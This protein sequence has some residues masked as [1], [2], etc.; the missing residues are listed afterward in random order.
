MLL[1]ALLLACASVR[2]DE[3]APEVEAFKS[4]LPEVRAYESDLGVRPQ[5]WDTPLTEG[6]IEWV[7][8]HPLDLAVGLHSL[9]VSFNDS[10][11]SEALFTSAGRLV[12]H[13]QPQTPPPAPATLDCPGLAPQ[14]RPAL[15]KLVASL[16]AAKKDVAASIAGLDPIKRARLESALGAVLVNQPLDELDAQLFGDADGFDRSAALRA[17]IEAAGAVEQALPDL[18]A[19]AGA[20]PKTKLRCGS[21]AGDVL[22]GTTGDDQYLPD[23]LE[24]SALVVDFGGANRY[25]GP[26]AAAG[27]GQLRVVLDLGSGASF[28]SKGPAAG[29]GRFGVG[30]LY[31]L[32]A[33]TT[34][35]KAGDYSAGA[36]FFG[37]GGAFIGGPAQVDTLSFGQG[38]GAFGVGLLE[39]R[40]T[41]RLSA[42]FAA[43]GFGFTRGVGLFLAR[44]TT[45][46][47]CGLYFPD[48]REDLAWLSLCQGVGY[49]PRAYAGG[50]WGVARV[51]GAGSRLQASY[52]A[53]GAGYWHGL[54]TL[55]V[56]GANTSL[57]ARRYSQGTGVHTAVGALELHADGV[58]TVNWGVG[59]GF[60]WDYGIGWLDAVGRGQKLRADWA[61][62]RA[63]LNSRS[64]VRIAGDSA[65]LELHD[66]GIGSY[67]RGAAGY[68]LVDIEGSGH[69]LREPLLGKP[70]PVDD[71]ALSPWGALW[72]PQSLTLDPTMPLDNVVWPTGDRQSFAKKE[73]A[74]LDRRLARVDAMAPAQRASALLFIV[75]QFGLAPE[76]VGR[77]V[78]KL[79]QT[80]EAEAA[81]LV[82]NVAPERFDELL[83]IRILACAL[84]RPAGQAAAAA[85]GQASGLKRALL[86]GLLGTSPIDTALD[87]ALAELRSSDWRV[88][89]QAAAVIGSLLDSSRGEEPG[90][91]AFLS[92]SLDVLNG[93]DEGAFLAKAG[94]KRLS[95][96]YAALALAGRLSV[97][98]RLSL[99]EKA[100]TPFDNVNPDALKLYVK[101]LRAFQDDAKKALSAE[102]DA[103]RTRKPAARAA[104]ID[105]AHDPDPEVAAT[106]LLALGRIGDPDDAPALQAALQAP[107]TLER[108]AGASALAAMGPAGA[109]AIADAFAAGSTPVRELAVVAAAQS[110]DP[111]VMIKVLKEAL[112]DPKVEVRR[113]AL[114]SLSAVP[115]PLHPKRRELVVDL[116]RVAG[117]DPA[118]ALRAAAKARLGEIAPELPKQ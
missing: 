62:G 60:G 58:S 94:V 65:Q 111:D 87:P 115:A 79:A 13:V 104:L 109:R 112:L 53:Q 89:K 26:A 95:D 76:A 61:A 18:R 7:L 117:S 17:A 114:A 96:L 11:D 5:R 27:P 83:W 9:D 67:Q 32:G 10:L 71:Y 59:P 42:R 107:T 85:I 81:A 39:L 1:P 63:D 80:P 55:L 23:E 97:P 29:S 35:I 88:R 56:D 43:E 20:A 3:A 12:G 46:A 82:S 4:L 25:A 75:S 24:T 92:D 102:L 68:S 91:L 116:Q 77:A 19:N 110:S 103:A 8:D 101:L 66:L 73:A 47:R 31:S 36:G 44:Q 2:A 16:A 100:G 99:L 33:G 28:E 34:T 52:F 72:A 86:V 49:G 15:E 70:A 14:L 90:R 37:V 30:L 78:E 105:A 84:G 74:E 57:Q 98:Y 108:E 22:L 113:L 118:P 50:G 40:G 38:A 51:D 6:G 45:D 54:G 93:G 106:A 64:F 48:P 21:P 69:R 41:S